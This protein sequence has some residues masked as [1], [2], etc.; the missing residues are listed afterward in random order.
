MIGGVPMKVKCGYEWK[1]WA[2]QGR[3]DNAILDEYP[4]LIADAEYLNLARVN[5]EIADVCPQ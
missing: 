4:R 2:L 3:S 1:L 5:A